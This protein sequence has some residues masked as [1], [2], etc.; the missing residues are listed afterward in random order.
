MADAN[1]EWLESNG[2]EKPAD[3]FR[4]WQSERCEKR[5]NIWL[6]GDT[7][8]WCCDLTMRMDE[9]DAFCYIKYRYGDTAED[10]CKGARKRMHE[11]LGKQRIR[12]MNEKEGE[13]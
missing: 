3:G 7:G 12:L 5:I 8:Y 2:F 13:I 4:N 10:A 1:Y 11:Y 6:D 9:L